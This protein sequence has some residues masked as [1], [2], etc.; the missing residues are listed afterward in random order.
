MASCQW[1]FAMV[2]DSSNYAD[3]FGLHWKTYRK[4]QLDSYSKTD[5]TKNRLM[6]CLGDYLWEKLNNG[7]TVKVLETGCEAGRFTEIL[8]QKVKNKETN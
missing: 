5:I 8:L 1:D 6:N 3:A 4:T 7:E 2:K